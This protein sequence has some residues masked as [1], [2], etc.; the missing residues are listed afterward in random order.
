[1][2]FVFHVQVRLRIPSKALSKFLLADSSLHGATSLFGGYCGPQY[3]PTSLFLFAS[4]TVGQSQVHVNLFGFNPRLRVLKTVK[5]WKIPLVVSDP[6]KMGNHQY[7]WKR[8][9]DLGVC[10]SWGILP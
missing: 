9:A 2:D 6:I 10:K 8:P 3:M 1:M 7:A 5:A 4:D